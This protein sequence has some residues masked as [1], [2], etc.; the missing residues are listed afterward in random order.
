MAQGYPRQTPERF[1]RFPEQGIRVIALAAVLALAG[2]ESGQGGGLTEGLD[3]AERSVRSKSAEAPREATSD[4]GR[5]I[6]EIDG[7]SIRWGEAKSH[8]AELG[9]RTVLTEL[10]LEQRLAR[11]C[12]AR[13][14]EIDTDALERERAIVERSL[15]SAGVAPGSREA[16]QLIAQIR[17]Q[18]GLGEARYAALIRR[19]AMLRALVGETS[20]PSEAEVRRAYDALYGERRV[21]RLITVSTLAEASRIARLARDGADF[22]DLATRFSTDVSAPRGG[23]LEPI[24]AQDER[25]P[26]AV[27]TALAGL[28]VGGVSGA[29]VLDEA[30]AVLR[31]ERIVPADDAAPSYEEARPA[32][33]EDARRRRERI[34]MGELADRLRPGARELQVFDPAL[35]RVWR[36]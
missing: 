13:G 20:E 4:P 15:L 14:I 22:A 34:L 27:R 17:E 32:L 35:D 8:L 2:C 26:Q 33:L 18:R 29:I 12:A 5:V 30:H 16:A 23:I 21:A 25:Y 24:S 1:D 6:A 9:G 10:A 36:E 19:N 3:R 28:E 11:R 7:D 31:L